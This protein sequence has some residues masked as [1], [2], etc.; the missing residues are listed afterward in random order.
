M[1]SLALTYRPQSFDDLVGQDNIKK[2]LS[3]QLEQNKFKQSYLFTGSAGTGKTTSARIFAKEIDGEIIEIDGASN[4]GVNDVRELKEKASF[5]PIHKKY[6]IIIIDEVHSLSIGAFNALLKILEEPPAHVIF[7]FATT[8]PQKIP[9]TILSRV[10]RFDFKRMSVQ[11][12]KSRLMYI[13][14]QENT[15]D[16][17]EINVSSDALEYISKLA[18]GGMRDAISVLDTCLGYQDNLELSDIFNILGTSNYEDV[19]NIM[20]FIVK[21]DY[22]NILDLIEELHLQGKNLKQ[23]VR[24]LLDVNVDLMKILLVKNWDYVSI[25]STYKE[26]AEELFDLLAEN[27][28]SLRQIFQKLSDLHQ[29]IKYESNEKTMIQ[30]ALVTL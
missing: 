18:N 23:F 24:N 7:V 19:F 2:I 13:I 22:A 26:E 1:K 27:E 11:Q 12:L 17:R 29:S 21:D 8:D 16:G 20:K 3:K 5:K 15:R 9:A 10:Q 6:K 4:N 30:G 28:K 25:P 14:E